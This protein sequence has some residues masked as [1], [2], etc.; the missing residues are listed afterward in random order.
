MIGTTAAPPAPP[1]A[2]VTAP[3]RP[4]WGVILGVWTAYWLLNSAQQNVLFSMSRGYPLPWWISLDL[5]MPLAY[6]WALATPGILWLARRFP[7]DRRAWPL[8]VLVHLVVS[9]AWVFLLDLGY[10]WHAANVLPLRPTPLLERAMG[11]FVSWVLSDGLLYWTMLSVSYAIEHYRRYREREL[12]ASQLETQLLQADLQ[13]LKMQLHPHFLFNALHTIGSLVR[14]GDRDNAVRVVTGLGD[15]LRRVLEGATQ[16]EVPLKQEL[17]FIRNYLNIEQI[18]FRDRLTVAINV[19]PET[20]DA[21]VPHLILQ[22]LVEN[23]IRHGIAPHRA[24]GRVVV[25]ARRVNDQLQ[26]IVRDDGPGIGNGDGS[27]ARPG[28]GLTNTRARLARLYGDD[29][30]LEVGNAEGGGLEARIA[31]PFQLAHA[32]WEGER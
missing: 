22:P 32:E 2:P 11:F 10:A 3:L 4:R 26:L 18:R 15:L 17:D 7:F 16:Q 25:V 1:S 19:D 9:C 21:K 30:E 20:L 29:Y 5:Q 14:T 24:A 12:I 23:A 8:S 31:V 6:S 27:T 28:I 13:A